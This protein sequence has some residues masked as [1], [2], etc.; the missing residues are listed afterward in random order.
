MLILY[1]LL[2]H[3]SYS[4]VQCHSIKSKAFVHDVLVPDFKIPFTHAEQQ[5]WNQRGFVQINRNLW[6]R[7][8]FQSKATVCRTVKIRTAAFFQNTK[9]LLH[10][11]NIICL[12]WLAELSWSI[13]DL[14]AQRIHLMS[15]REKPY[16]STLSLWW[17]HLDVLR[18]SCQYNQSSL[19]CSIWSDYCISGEMGK[20]FNFLF[21]I[22]CQQTSWCMLCLGHF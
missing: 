13:F 5:L 2:P 4:N 14:N 20:Y 12:C 21:C 9:F 8:T 18:V 15:W 6:S 11:R 17:P 19:I 1:C 10:N 22:L 16:W 3:S 7:L